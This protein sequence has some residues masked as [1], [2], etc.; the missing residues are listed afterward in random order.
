MPATLMCSTMDS[1][2]HKMNPLGFNAANLEMKAKHLR[3]L[4]RMAS[5]SESHFAAW[6][7][8]P[9]MDL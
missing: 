4:R 1:A 3:T 6:R 5:S 9:T 8:L 2:A 7:H